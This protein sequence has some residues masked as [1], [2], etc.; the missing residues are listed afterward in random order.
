MENLARQR[1][2]NHE[3]REAAARCPECGRYYCRE[4]ITEHDERVL[5]A[6]CL[7]KLVRGRPRM[8]QRLAPLSRGL[9]CFLGLLIL[10]LVFY[11]LG[12]VLLSLPASF[13]DVTLW[14]EQWWEE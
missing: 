3:A 14:Q 8:R 1:C 11:F 12:S 7:K 9:Q 5:C 4:C 13:H 2:V 10:W 6:A